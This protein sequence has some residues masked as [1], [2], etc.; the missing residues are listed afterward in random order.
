MSA[1]RSAIT[2][3]SITAIRDYFTAEVCGAMARYNMAPLVEGKIL[4]GPQHVAEHTSP[5]RIIFIPKG[6]KFGPKSV[7]A[8]LPGP[9]ATPE[10]RREVQQRSIGTEIL[11]I[12]V[13]C[14][15]QSTPADDDEDWNVAR[16]L[17]HLVMQAAE[18]L[19]AGIW[20]ATSGSWTDSEPGAALLNRAGREFR[21][22]LEIGTPILG[23]LL[24]YVPAGT[25]AELTVE[26]KTPSGTV[27]ETVVITQ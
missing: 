24:P 11:L 10:K 18:V 5:P 23:D 13:R 3:P 22:M 17:A 4:L 21:F 25:K 19:T 20:N 15:G 1:E 2:P 26:Q 6:S 8:A 16:G 27:E 7:T 14:W 9:S 12:E